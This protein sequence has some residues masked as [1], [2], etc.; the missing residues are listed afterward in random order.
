MTSY[1]VAAN[2]NNV[3][4]LVTLTIEPAQPGGI[5][6]PDALVAVDG[7]TVFQGYPATELVWNAL[8]DPADRA[9]VLAA[10][11]LAT[12]ANAAVTA[13]KKVTVRVLDNDHTWV[14]LN[15]WAH[16]PASVKR[17][18]LGWE[19]CRILLTYLHAPS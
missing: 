4:G 1:Q 19:D 5:V 9:A 7:S 12:D 15:A 13:S 2:W 3:A 17:T 8:L 16:A 6:W 10:F 14:N 11:G 18:F